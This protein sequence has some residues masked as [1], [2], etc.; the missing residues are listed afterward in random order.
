MKGSGLRTRMGAWAIGA[1]FAW[2][3][4]GG[5]LVGLGLDWL[6]G[7]SPIFL[8]IFMIG[9]LIGGFAIFLRAGLKGSRAYKPPPEGKA[10]ETESSRSHNDWKKDDWPDEDWK[11]DDP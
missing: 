6:F 2:T 8:L 7:T 9:G 5:V 10:P 1:D 3:V 4:I 11:K